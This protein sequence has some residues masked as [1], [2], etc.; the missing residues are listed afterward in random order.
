ME[1]L[2]G[3]T[4]RGAGLVLRQAVLVH[5]PVRLAT[6]G[7]LARVEHKRLLEA[8]ATSVVGAA[9]GPVRARG[10]PVA[11]RRD[12][13]GARSVGVLLVSWAE[14][15]PLPLTLHERH[16]CMPLNISSQIT[17]LFWNPVPAKRRFDTARLVELATILCI[18]YLGVPRGRSC[19]DLT[20]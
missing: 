13:V 19:R 5:D 17:R 7:S 6:A 3:L 1:A 12:S 8:N 11:R 2:E 14:E 9:H 18:T 10:L 16:R 4:K 20:H 15:E